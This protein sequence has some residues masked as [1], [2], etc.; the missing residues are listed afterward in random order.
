MVLFRIALAA[1]VCLAADGALALGLFVS[2]QVTPQAEYTFGIEGPAIDA[3]G[4]LYVVNFRKQGTIGRLRP[5]AAESELFTELP[6]GSIGSAI[7]FDRNGRMYIADYK[8]HNVFVIDNG[9]IEPRVYFHSDTFNQPN[10]LTLAQNGTIYASDP[11]WKRRDGQVWR[12][13]AGSDGTV[14][15]EVMVSGRKM[16]TTNGIDLSPDGRTLYVGES[17]SR[18][19]WAYRIEGPRLVA[20]R[21]IK[22]FEDFSLDGLRTDVEGRIFVTRILKGTV[23]VLSPDG[24]VEREIVLRA[25]E[26]TNLAFGGPDGKTVFVAQRQGGFIEAFRTNRPGREFCLQ[27]AQAASCQT[28]GAEGGK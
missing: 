25:K 22:R 9:Q 24:K 26:P 2:S 11:S 4:V 18:E 27:Q 7:R 8:G 17:E 20:P 10:D 13:A 6:A 28:R 14:Q 19:L 15:G 1:A 16:G 3:A 12:I 5:G 21:L 23:A